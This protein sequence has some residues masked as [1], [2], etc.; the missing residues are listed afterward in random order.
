MQKTDLDTLPEG[1]HRVAPNLF[2]SV[3][4]ENSKSWLFRARWN[5]SSVKI[6]LGSYF[7]VPLATAKAKAAKLQA[8]VAEGRDPRLLYA[9]KP[10]ETEKP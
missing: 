6:G 4:N 7:R 10:K 9:D 5:G 8:E 2:L 1:T 3:R